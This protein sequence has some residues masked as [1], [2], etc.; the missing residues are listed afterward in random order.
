MNALAL[1]K[2]FPWALSALMIVATLWYRGNY[3]SE[4][5]LRATQAAISQA[6]VRSAEEKALSLSN[7]LVI[8]Q[9]QAMAITEKT[10]TL[11][12]DRIVHVPVTIVCA[13]S[14]AMR[15]ASAGVRQLIQPG[16]GPTPAGR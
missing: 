1:L 12:Q 8:A 13:Q 5:A 16:G 4:K 2:F 9:A 14:P 10:V 7:E 3:E 6:S 15:D 11:Y